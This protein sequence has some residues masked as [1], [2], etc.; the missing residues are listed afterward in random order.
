MAAEDGAPGGDDA[1]GTPSVVRSSLRKLIAYAETRVR[2]VANESEEQL[3]R[4]LEIG[5]WSVVGVFFFAVALLI[6][7]IFL[8]LAF[9][10]TQR[11]L[12]AGIL[13]LV[14]IAAGAWCLLNVRMRLAARPRFLAVT[15]EEFERDKRDLDRP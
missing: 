3:L 11:V 4:L 13:T 9:W 12:V 15:L 6:G 10:D 8:I 5:L 14:Y 2:I 7:S 1:R